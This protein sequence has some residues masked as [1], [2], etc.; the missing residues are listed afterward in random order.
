MSNGGT[1]AGFNIYF[2]KIEE[3][4]KKL[5]CDKFGILHCARERYLVKDGPLSFLTFDLLHIFTLVKVL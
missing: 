5:H 4:G 1:K 2:F 3:I